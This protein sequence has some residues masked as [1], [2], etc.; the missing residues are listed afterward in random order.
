MNNAPVQRL[1]QDSVHPQIFHKTVG[2][3]NY[4]NSIPYK[5]EKLLNI[6]K[7]KWL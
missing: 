7:F 4:I 6:S 1:L 3:A 5:E 2:A